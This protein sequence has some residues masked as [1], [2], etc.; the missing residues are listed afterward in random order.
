MDD[1][2]L[3]SYVLI[4]E[5]HLLKAEFKTKNRTEPLSKGLLA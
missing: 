5:L 2:A 1:I 4:R 3:V